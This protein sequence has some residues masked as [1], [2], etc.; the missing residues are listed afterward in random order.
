MLIDDLLE[1]ARTTQAPMALQTIDLSEIAQ[2][3]LQHLAESQPERKVD[4]RIQ[5]GMR[6]TADLNLM[7]IA[8]DNLL[9]NAWKYSDKQAH[10]RIEFGRSDKGGDETYFIK[11]NGIGFD[12]R[13]ADKLFSSFQRLHKASE[14]EGTGIGL[15]TVQRIIHR[16]GGRIWGEAE[17]NKGAS[18]YFTI[19]ERKKFDVSEGSIKK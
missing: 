14:Y 19:S 10:A 4:V 12:M 18:F 3:I 7:K 15:A 13:F 5:P 2:N 6:V 17:P 16:H 8:L 9:G 11:D 1:L